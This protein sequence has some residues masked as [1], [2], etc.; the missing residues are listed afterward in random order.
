MFVCEI[1]SLHH[2]PG[3]VWKQGS[4]LFQDKCNS[5]HHGYHIA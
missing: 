2:D 3:T 1:G 4:Y 5:L